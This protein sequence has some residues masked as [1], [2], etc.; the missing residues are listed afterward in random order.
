MP[1]VVIPARW[2]SVRFPGKPLALIAGKSLVQ[3][4][5]EQ[6]RQ[7][8][9]A[10]EI[11][12]ATEDERI[13]RAA[14]AFGADARM[15]SA[16]HAT[17]SDRV[18]EIA[19][20]SKQDIIVNVQGDEPLIDPI[21]IDAAI[22]PLQQEASIV[23]SSLMRPLAPEEIDNPNIV[24]VV[25][26]RRGDSIYFSRHAIPYQRDRAPGEPPIPRWAHIGIYCFR[27]T[28]LLEYT[29]MVPTPL[30]TAERLEQLRILENG[31]R[32]RMVP[33][34]YIGFGVDTPDD[35]T[36]TESLLAARSSPS[37]NSTNGGPK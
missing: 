26:D 12:V 5:W 8:R 21:A 11:V 34:D 33:T 18:A 3:R 31:R 29:R 1:L 14:R 36:R 9:L 13:I 15:T 32:L 37:P 22:R 19:S 6:A 23:A 10:D 4:V 35:V 25:V 24:K 2:A 28:F 17:G 16:D 7:S 27:R 30:E 20:G